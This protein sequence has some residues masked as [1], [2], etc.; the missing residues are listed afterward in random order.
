MTGSIARESPCRR[1]SMRSSDPTGNDCNN[2]RM[3]VS[4]EMLV[5]VAGPL[6]DEGE[7]WFIE[8][9]DTLVQGVGFR[10]FLPHRDNPPKTADN[11]RDIYLNDRGAIDECGL[12]VAN[13]NGLT[14]DDGTAWG[15]RLRLRQGEAG[16]R[17]LLRLA[18]A[19]PP[20]RK[21]EPHDR[22]VARSD[23]RIT[24]RV[25]ARPRALPGRALSR[26][27]YRCLRRPPGRS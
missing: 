18:P 11:A 26:L 1:R 20:W 8:T 9:I 15:A 13:L 7:R 24:R 25:A 19:L 27:R 6:F 17:I 16:D 23:R 22:G 21:G 12:I 5:Y 2:W 3:I 14:T 10:T 4:D